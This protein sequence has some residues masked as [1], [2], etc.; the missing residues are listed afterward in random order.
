MKTKTGKVT[1][2]SLEQPL[3]QVARQT[4]EMHRSVS[5]DGK[6]LSIP[7]VTREGVHLLGPKYRAIA[8]KLIQQ[9]RL[10]LVDRV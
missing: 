9:N 4:N 8:E 3:P 7:I 1:G 5:G 10:V 2:V 6:K